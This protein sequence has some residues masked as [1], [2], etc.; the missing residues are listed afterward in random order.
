MRCAVLLDPVD[1]GGVV[2]EP[3]GGFFKRIWIQLQKGQ[4]MFI[5]S[6]GF[7]IVSVEQPFSMKSGLVNQSRQMH[8]TAQ[9]I[10]RTAWKQFLH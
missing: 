5:E 1:D 2:L 9:T 7:V 10:V 6:N 8:V 4:K 3:M